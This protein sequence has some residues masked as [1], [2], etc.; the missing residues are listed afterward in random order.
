MESRLPDGLTVAHFSVLN[1]CMRVKDG[2]T[3]LVLARAF[4]V[5]KTTMTHT[6]AGLEK[7]ALIEIRQNPKDKRSKCVWIANKGKRFRMDA[8]AALDP[9]MIVFAE[10]FPKSDIA[11]LIPRLAEIR[12]MLDGYRDGGQ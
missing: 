7:R 11:M 8:I 12:A 2:Q 6:L 4:Q 3:P 10:Q 1:H 5:P 9:D